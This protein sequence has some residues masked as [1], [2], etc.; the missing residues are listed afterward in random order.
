[1]IKDE[2]KMRESM[3]E[4]VLEEFRRQGFRITK[5]RKLILDILL[6]HRF[7]CKKAICYYVH[8]MDPTIGTATV[9]RMLQVLEQMGLLCPENSYKVHVG[10]EE[11]EKV[12]I[13]I[14][15]NQEKIVLSQEEWEGAFRESLER[16]GYHS[17][18]IEKVII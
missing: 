11:L 1:M 2:H 18:E 7:E 3:K 4:R 15:K 13:I 17:Q 9:Y 8:Q 16:L 12:C 5:Q 10:G 6:N 14:M